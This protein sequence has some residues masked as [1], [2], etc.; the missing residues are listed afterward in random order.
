[1]MAQDDK[2]GNDGT[3]HASNAASQIDK[4]I[5]DPS[6]ASGYVRTI[7]GALQ[8]YVDKCTKFIGLPTFRLLDQ[9]VYNVMYKTLSRQRPKEGIVENHVH[10]QFTMDDLHR[11]AKVA[12]QARFKHE[13]AR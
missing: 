1:M 6:I 3:D 12:S 4:Y 7:H 5:S 2:G 8:F 9:P 13:L 10:T 11:S